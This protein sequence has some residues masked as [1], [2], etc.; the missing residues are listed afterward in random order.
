MWKAQKLNILEPRQLEQSTTQTLGSPETRRRRNSITMTFRTLGNSKRG[1][2]ETQEIGN[3][4]TRK[5]RNP[6]ARTLRDSETWDPG[7]YWNHKFGHS[8][9]HKLW[10]SGTSRDRTKLSHKQQIKQLT[11]HCFTKLANKFDKNIQPQFRPRLQWDLDQA[12]SGIQTKLP[13]R[14]RL[15]FQSDF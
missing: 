9:T 13:S 4:E 1:N 14:F 15:S 12:F 10:N 8:E 3:S 5:I 2:S 7:N 11:R 6:V